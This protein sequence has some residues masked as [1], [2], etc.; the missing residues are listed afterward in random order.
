MSP[1]EALIKEQAEFGKTQ[2]KEAEAPS[3]PEALTFGFSVLGKP[4]TKVRNLTPHTVTVY[5]AYGAVPIVIEPDPAGPVQVDLRHV[6]LGPYV[7]R[8][9]IENV[10]G[11]PAAEPGV[12]LLVSI[13]CRMHIQGRDD[14]LTPSGVV[15]DPQGRIVGCRA[16]AW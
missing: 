5:G 1:I 4:V 16:L 7:S 13:V 8:P 6:A 15:R 11:L 12:A 10:R 9:V 14:F 3:V 2:V